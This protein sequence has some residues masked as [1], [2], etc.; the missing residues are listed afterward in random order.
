MDVDKGLLRQLPSPEPPRKEVQET[1]VDKGSLMAIRLTSGDS[2][3]VNDRPISVGRL[4]EETV[5]FVHRLG[6]RHLISIVSDRDANYDLY[7]QM[8]NQLAEA[9][10]QLRDEAALQK[11]HKRY[12]L[13][14]SVQKETVRESCP[15]RI[16][17]SYANAMVY[18]DKS[19]DANAE[20][21]QGEETKASDSF[22]RKNKKG[23]N[24]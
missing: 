22:S 4:K 20:E 2:L 14:S 9:Y 15:Q 12:A 18:S 13:L 24:E 17:E 6:K 8:Q 23:G 10:A 21:K 7:F 19:V 3:L 1:V 11:F 16:T 5:R